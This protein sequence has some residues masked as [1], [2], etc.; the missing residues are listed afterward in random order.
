M[1]KCDRHFNI[2][3]SQTVSHEPKS[4]A[5][6]ILKEANN[7]MITIYYRIKIPRLTPRNDIVK[8]PRCPGRLISNIDALYVSVKDKP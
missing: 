6:V 7:L 2:Q 4:I 3:G 5:F 8:Q 1:V